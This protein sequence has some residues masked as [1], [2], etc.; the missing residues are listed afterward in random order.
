M[1]LTKEQWIFLEK[2]MKRKP[3]KEEIE[4]I[5]R[6]KEIFKDYPLQY[7]W[8]KTNHMSVERMFNGNNKV[9]GIALDDSYTAYECTVCNKIYV[10]EGWAKKHVLKHGKFTYYKYIQLVKIGLNC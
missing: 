2:E 8:R 7:S 9:L 10:K 1:I 3:I 6:I 5:R 4:K